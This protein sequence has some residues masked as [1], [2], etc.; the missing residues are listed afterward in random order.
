MVSLFFRP[1]AK[2]LLAKLVPFATFD[3][4]LLRPPVDGKLA[5]PVEQPLLLHHGQV[6]FATLLDAAV[7]VPHGP[8]QLLVVHLY[9]SIRLHQAPRAGKIVGVVH[10]EDAVGLVDPADHARVVEPVVQQ[11]P[12]KDVDRRKWNLRCMLP[13]SASFSA[14]VTL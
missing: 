3:V 1:Q 11:V 13:R 14:S 7:V 5:E 10:P 4:D 2:T 9:S 12:N 8:G 6:A